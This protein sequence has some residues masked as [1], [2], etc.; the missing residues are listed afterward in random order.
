MDEVRSPGDILRG[1]E[2]LRGTGLGGGTS[3]EQVE[4][5]SLGVGLAD[6]AGGNRV[7]RGGILHQV[8]APRSVVGCRGGALQLA[9]YGGAPGLA[10]YGGVSDTAGGEEEKE[11]GG[12]KAKVQRCA[13]ADAR[14]TAGASGRNTKTF[15]EESENSKGVGLSKKI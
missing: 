12:D 1:G 9:G 11:R 3:V 10:G 13:H 4:Q 6:A 2:G 14:I 8:P 15:L 5:A 7:T